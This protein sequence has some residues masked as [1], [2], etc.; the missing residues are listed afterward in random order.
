MLELYHN[1][2]SVCAQ[3]VRLV[4]AEKKVPTLEHHMNLR[5]GESHTPEYLRLNP[6]GV[7]PTL[8]DNGRPI[9]ESTIICEYLDDAY[10]N[11]PLKPEDPL[12]LAEMRQWT[13]LLDAELHRA[14]GMVSVGVA[15]RHQIVAAGGAQIKGIERDLARLPFLDVIERGIDSPHVAAGLQIY[16]KA[17][18]RMSD[19]L[20]GSDWLAGDGYS[21]ADAAMM[22]YIL[23]LKHLEME[24]LWEGDRRDAIEGWLERSRT[25]ANYRGISDYLDEGYIQ[26]ARDKGRESAPRLKA[27]RSDLRV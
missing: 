10:P 15:W 14:C 8:V 21:L 19:H 17:V 11:P 12:A 13:L 1:N 2:M 20:A 5:A 24:W 27:M 4:L 3:K 6:K 26:L 16:D 22:P 23:R 18:G 25:R 7:V 9:V